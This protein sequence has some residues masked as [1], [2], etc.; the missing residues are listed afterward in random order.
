VFLYEF[1]Y[2]LIE[3]GKKSSNIEERNETASRYIQQC[4]SQGFS[5][6]AMVS[7]YLESLDVEDD[8]SIFYYK[9]S[10]SLF[11]DQHQQTFPG[12]YKSC[13]GKLLDKVLM[14][15]KSNEKVDVYYISLITELLGLIYKYEGPEDIGRSIWG[16]CCEMVDDHLGKAFNLPV[17]AW[18]E[19]FTSEKSPVY[20]A[21][22]YLAGC[23]F[24]LPNSD[25]VNLYSWLCKYKGRKDEMNAIIGVLKEYGAYSA[26]FRIC[27][28]E[29]KKGIISVIGKKRW[30]GEFYRLILHLFD[31]DDQIISGI[32][33]G[34]DGVKSTNEEL[35]FC[36][37]CE[38]M[39]DAYEEDTD[40]ERFRKYL[41][42]VKK[43]IPYLRSNRNNKWGG[44]FYLLLLL[45]FHNDGKFIRYL[46]F[47]ML[48]DKA[49]G[50]TQVFCEFCVALA[51]MYEK[52]KAYQS[53][54][55]VWTKTEGFC[56]EFKKD[57]QNPL[58]RK[59]VK[60]LERLAS[61]R[62]EVNKIIDWLTPA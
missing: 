24:F 20:A 59:V 48:E 16:L 11:A 42:H 4:R 58:Y 9:Y 52:H 1:K 19:R 5:V 51:G 40:N 26:G 31:F 37:L 13:V 35:A 53:I 21:A 14:T 36:E 33:K 44:E 43:V 3:I 29:Y 41:A 28:D 47:S 6:E 25:R 15:D 23:R 56:R 38:E 27:G 62:P 17:S 39:F 32:L 7:L 30:S 22:K 45:H 12:L 54:N 55:D 49:G 18:E 60:E 34:L 61:K 57:S 8:K 10:T 2:K 50:G 46:M